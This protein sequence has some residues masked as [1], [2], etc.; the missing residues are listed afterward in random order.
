MK[1]LTGSVRSFLLAE[2]RVSW[3]SKKQSGRASA[4]ETSHIDCVSPTIILSLPEYGGWPL[5]GGS[6]DACKHNVLPDPGV[7]KGRS[8][9]L[10]H[11]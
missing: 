2:T 10:F 1:A 5:N 8:T 7:A 4:S 11:L 6:S 3:P 9:L